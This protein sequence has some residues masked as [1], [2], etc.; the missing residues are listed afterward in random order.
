MSCIMNNNWLSVYIYSTDLNSVLRLVV[1]EILKQGKGLYSRFFFIRYYEPGSHV[2]LRLSCKQVSQRN[3]LQLLISKIIQREGCLFEFVPY[4]P[5]L[6]RYGG[7]LGLEFAESF[8][9]FS[10]RFVLDVISKATFNINV[11]LGIA[12]KLQMIFINSFFHS[13]NE[14]VQFLA[15]GELS[16]NQWLIDTGL[17]K[18]ENYFNKRN[19]SFQRQKEKM[20]KSLESL[21]IILNAQM[22]FEDQLLEEW[23]DKTSYYSKKFDCSFHEFEFKDSSINTA[24]QE[25]CG[26]RKWL[27]AQS[28]IHMHNNRLGILYEDEAF[29]FMALKHFFEYQITN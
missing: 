23:Q 20:F 8:F 25:S 10:S 16:W 14:R 17:V 12:L 15:F 9:Q 13:I 22:C 26:Y 11:A 18:D 21:Q 28:Y 3:K 5:E 4:M 24:K 29:C 1:P 2:R 27:L 19:E 7:E 6:I